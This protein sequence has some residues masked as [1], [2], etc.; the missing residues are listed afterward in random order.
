MLVDVCRVLRHASCQERCYTGSGTEKS[1]ACRRQKIHP[2]FKPRADAPQK[3]KS[4][5]SPKSTLCPTKINKN[6]I[7][8]R[9]TNFRKFYLVFISVGSFFLATISEFTISSADFAVIV[10]DTASINPGG[11][12][13]PA[14]GAFTAPVNGYY[15]Y[16]SKD[17][18]YL[19]NVDLCPK[20][21]K[22]WSSQTF[23]KCPVAY[24]TCFRFSVNKEGDNNSG[25]F[26]LL[27]DG[28]SYLYKSTVT[29][30]NPNPG[31][32]IT[33]N[34]ELAAGQT[35]TVQNTLSSVIYGTSD[36]G[37]GEHY[38]WFTGHLLMAL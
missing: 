7:F 20:K 27:V 31:G 38:S 32:A 16:V 33:I 30:S 26:R 36:T 29:E 10:F 23:R 9:S 17:T 4:D 14:T 35:V 1:I 34:I 24:G 6:N 21:K 25:A 8:L 3:W 11:N 18:Y 28:Q 2:S 12:Y 13:N 5:A 15:Q 22:I 19:I 37:S